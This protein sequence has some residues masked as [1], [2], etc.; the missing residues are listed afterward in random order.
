MTDAKKPVVAPSLL[1]VSPEELLRYRVVSEVRAQ[2]DAGKTLAQAIDAAW[3]HA[4]V[5]TE[6]HP[7][8][9]SERSAYRWFE[10]HAKAGLAGLSNAMSSSKPVGGCLPPTLLDFFRSEKGVD[11]YASVPELIR[12]ARQRGIIDA[13]QPVDRVTAYRACV[14]LGLPMRRVPGKYESD[15]RRFAYPHRM[16]MVLADGKHFR[17]GLH[18]TRRVALFF[19]D[20]ASRYGLDVIVVTAESAAGFLR[21]L[22]AV[23][24]RTGL[25]DS[26]FLDNG[27]GFKADDTAAV[28][29]RL[30]INLILGTAGYPEG[31]G[32]IER[33][34]QTAG[35]QVLR[36][37]AG[38]A[39]VDD[40]CGALTLRLR[41]WL[42]T[43]YNQTPHESLDLLSPQS[44]WELDSKAL[45]PLESQDAL[46]ERFVVREPRTVSK[47]NVVSFESIDYEVPRGHARTQIQVQRR[48]LSG[49]LLVLHDGRLVTLHPVDLALNAVSGRTRSPVAPPDDSESTPQTAAA[50]A[51]ARAFS[52]VVNRDGGCVDP[53]PA[54]KNG[55]MP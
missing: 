23:I 2:L 16:M 19:L 18:K 26:L 12:R 41:H 30:G 47:D 28:C 5:T 33:F 14:A 17:A 53:I 3:A 15:M 55:E 21:G 29:V 34:N 20:D 42:H 9:V 43:Q 52:P 25:M 40:D 37:L 31:H 8:T 22:Y 24:L 44:R 4:Y 1:S 54:T 6:G 48:V 11:R 50:L 51:F 46:R 38:A 39:E 49:E 45:R 32:K 7:Q 27:P 36:G 13:Q 10:A 35:T